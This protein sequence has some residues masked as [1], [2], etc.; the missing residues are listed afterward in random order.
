MSTITKKNWIT[1]H[2]AHIGTVLLLLGVFCLTAKA[3]SP[4]YLDKQGILDE[5]FFLLPLGYG[6]VPAALLLCL[7][8]GI[9]F[10]K[11]KFSK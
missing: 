2:L 8:V 1:S 11:N 7:A 4:E 3:L 5:S 10:L 9:H 6:L